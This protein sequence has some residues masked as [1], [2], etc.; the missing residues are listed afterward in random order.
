MVA[1][2][3]AVA[4]VYVWSSGV[5]SM[6]ARRK[7]FAVLLSIGWRPSQLS[8]L[9]VTESV[10]IGLFVALLSWTMLSLIHL[11]G[12]ATISLT[13]FFWTGFLGLIIYVLGAIVPSILVRHISPFETMR[14]GEV[15]KTSRRWFGTKG[16]VTMAL[17]QYVGKWK[18]NLLSVLS[19]SLPTSLLAVFLYITVRLQGIMYTTLLGEYLTLEIGPVH[20]VAIVVSLV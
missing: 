12:D 8:R 13:R 5:I 14:T 7:E 15:T 3:V 10:I 18:R 2:V 6:L 17:N 4:V 20:Y 9:I 19:I 1:S 16:I 11:S